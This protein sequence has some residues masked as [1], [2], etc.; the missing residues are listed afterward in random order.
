VALNLS[1]SIAAQPSSAR[2]NGNIF[3]IVALEPAAVIQGFAN[4]MR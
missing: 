2:I 4:A 3:L 1:I